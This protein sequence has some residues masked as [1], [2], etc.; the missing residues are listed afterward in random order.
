MRDEVVT[1]KIDKDINKIG[2]PNYDTRFFLSIRS[3]DSD[4][5]SK[6]L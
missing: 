3:V 4:V 6:I 1:K 2:A 5:N